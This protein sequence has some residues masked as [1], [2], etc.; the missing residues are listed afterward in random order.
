MSRVGGLGSVLFAASMSVSD[1]R[2][3]PA[4]AYM[5]LPAFLLDDV[6]GLPPGNTQVYLDALLVVLKE[7]EPPA[8][9]VT[10]VA[11]ALIVP[12]G[13]AAVTVAS[14]THAACDGT[15]AASKRKTM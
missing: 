8:L 12:A 6:A 15:P 10:S 1:A 4:F 14:S 3:F 13:G 2:Y 5:T 11:G 9:I 7:T